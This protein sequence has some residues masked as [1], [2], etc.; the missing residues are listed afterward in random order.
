MIQANKGKVLT[1]FHLQSLEIRKLE[2]QYF[3][4]VLEK[5]SSVAVLLAGFSSK[6]IAMEVSRNSNPVIITAFLASSGCAFGFNL[7]VILIATLCSLWAPGKALLGDDGR[8]VHEAIAILDKSTQTAV[9]FFLFGLFSYFV[10]SIMVTWLLFD[11]LSAMIVTIFLSLTCMGVLRQITKL[12]QCFVGG[13][14]TTGY[15]HGN[16]T[17]QI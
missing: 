2:L 6:I 8:H 7:L 17:R 12:R 5:L 14:I 4:L 16:P 11:P 10:A 1:D 9:R 3:I 13:K 15:L